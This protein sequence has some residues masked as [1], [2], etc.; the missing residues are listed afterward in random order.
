MNIR[1]P[2]LLVWITLLAGSLSACKVVNTHVVKLTSTPVVDDKSDVQ[3]KTT[4]GKVFLG[5]QVLNAERR[6]LLKGVRPFQCVEIKTSEPWDMS[7]REVRF[8]DY[9]IKKL[10]ETDPDCLKLKVGPRISLD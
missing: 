6:E 4:V 5:A 1:H 8:N 3:L 2:V 10:P 9:R 7:H